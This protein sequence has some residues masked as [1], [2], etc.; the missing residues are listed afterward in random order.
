MIIV[1][2]PPNFT[3]DI[4]D[5]G[6]FIDHASLSSYTPNVTITRI[7]KSQ[8]S[9]L[10]VYQIEQIS[11]L[12]SSYSLT[13]MT[14]AVSSQPN[15]TAIRRLYQE[16][17]YEIIADIPGNSSHI[18]PTQLLHIFG[19]VLNLQ[20]DDT[21]TAFKCTTI[22]I[23]DFDVNR[24]VCLKLWR[25]LAAWITSLTAGSRIQVRNLLLKNNNNELHSTSSTE[26]YLL[27]H[28]FRNNNT[29]LSARIDQLNQKEREI[30]L[31]LNHQ[32]LLLPKSHH[33]SFYSS[34][35]HLSPPFYLQFNC[36]HDNCWLLQG[37]D[38]G[39]GELIAVYFRHFDA[40]V[41]QCL[42]DLFMEPS[43]DNNHHFEIVLTN[44]KHAEFNTFEFISSSSLQPHPQNNI[45]SKSSKFMKLDWND[46]ISAKVALYGTFE[47]EGLLEQQQQQSRNFS[48]EE[49]L[50]NLSILPDEQRS[51][52]PGLF[53]KCPTNPNWNVNIENH[54]HVSDTITP[55]TFI[56]NI[57]T[58]L[59]EGNVHEI[60][61]KSV[62]IVNN[63][64]F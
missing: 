56:V 49:S 22:L 32:S 53:L 44:L 64:H 19:I 37:T 14:A 1:F 63:T 51:Q 46:L 25:G 3:N 26:I 7:H 34:N 35:L 21:A 36:D 31:F 18:L 47:I 57:Q 41:W 58:I 54:S 60:I 23:F 59:N 39:S 24:P 2:L 33:D 5:D 42:N 61:R 28:G 50:G 55:Y 29:K 9:S 17:K 27:A 43:R 20:S 38:K 12:D 10:L 13:Q 15:P 62:F 16:L 45:S 48:S 52:P 30:L 11:E 4:K 8:D 40:K 6:S